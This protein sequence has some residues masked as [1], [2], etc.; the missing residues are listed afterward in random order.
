MTNQAQKRPFASLMEQDYDSGLNDNLSPQP[1]LS[2]MAIDTFT[3]DS[4]YTQQQHNDIYN[5]TSD[6]IIDHKHFNT[7]HYQELL[8]TTYHNQEQPPQQHYVPN[9]SHQP[10]PPESQPQSISISNDQQKQ[11]SIQQQ[12]RKM[13]KQEQAYCIK[14]LTALMKHRKAIAFLQPVDVVAFNIPDYLDIIKQPMDL[15]TISQKLNTHQYESVDAF[16]AD[17]RLVFDNCF[18]YNNAQDPVSLD[19]KKLEEV[20][21][22]W[23]KKRPEPQLDTTAETNTKN[24]DSNNVSETQENN[25]NNDTNDSGIVEDDNTTMDQVAIMPDDQFKRCEST[26]KELKKGKHSDLNWPF[27]LPVNAEAWGATD[28]YQII[29]H[30]MDLSTVERKLG[31][32]EYGNEDEFEKDIR[33]IFANCYAY[34]P[35]E[36][37]VH[38]LGKKLEHLFESFWK[39]IHKK[40]SSKAKKDSKKLDRKIKL[41]TNVTKDTN[42][43]AS[44]I[45]NDQ[46]TSTPSVE[47]VRPPTILRLK[48]TTKPSEEPKSNT[49]TPPPSSTAIATPQQELKPIKNPG[50]ALSTEPRTESKRPKLAIGSKISPPPEKKP[51]KKTPL[52]LQNHDKWLALA[53]KS[54]STDDM[55]SSILTPPSS[56][57]SAPPVTTSTIT[58]TTTTASAPPKPKETAPVP[59]KTFDITEYIDRMKGENR[60]RDQQ[61]R[62]EEEQR[63]EKDRQFMEKKQQAFRQLEEQRKEHKEWMEQRKRKDKANRLA[64]LEHHHVDISKQKLMFHHFESTALNRDQDWRDLF[65]W[66]RDTVDY[67][68]M[69]APG[70]VR[71]ANLNLNELR[72]QILTKGIRLRPQQDT[73]NKM[74]MDMDIE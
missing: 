39:K 68:R 26:I 48:L 1:S 20:F 59:T 17:V 23:L 28:Y 34:N 3:D 33:L 27:L 67:R 24:I 62:E 9:Y 37:A 12:K 6:K 4:V 73:D 64:S 43:V 53:Q 58:N 29:S 63:K 57:N 50:L 51:E 45:I 47:E 35:P 10:S 5:E 72:R 65:I 61:K 15:G 36:H 69:P 13:S 38:Q 46:K 30:P 70:F 16:L 60:V 66:E 22:K 40:A 41:V 25:K 74:E 7:N 44:T 32:Y 14:T 42:E 21:E 71:R 55:E 49:P 2:P 19:A 11:Q 18:L 54:G 31:D 52:V 8:P 56:I